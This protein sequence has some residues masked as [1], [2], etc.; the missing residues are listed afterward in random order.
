MVW[1]VDWTGVWVDLVELV[2]EEAVVLAYFPFLVERCAGRLV[3]A[4]Y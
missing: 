3:L 1:Q 2:L 4:L